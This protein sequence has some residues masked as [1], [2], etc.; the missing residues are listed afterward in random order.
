MWGGGISFCFVYISH[1]SDHYCH[2]VQTKLCAV[3][4]KRNVVSGEEGGLW[5]W[6]VVVEME[7][8]DLYH[9]HDD[10]HKMKMPR[11]GDYFFLR[12][13]VPVSYC[14]GKDCV[15][16]VVGAACRNVGTAGCGVL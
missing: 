8:G 11:E 1:Y 13:L 9:G 4:E 3:G 6:V 14:A 7:V 10:T 5:G 2:F 16:S 12:E 15:A